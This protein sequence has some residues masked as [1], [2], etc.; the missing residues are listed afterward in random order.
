MKNV[1]KTIILTLFIGVVALSSFSSNEK[2]SNPS[3]KEYLKQQQTV[4]AYLLQGTNWTTGYV[5]YRCNDYGCNP[6]RWQFEVSDTSEYN[7]QTQGDFY[8]GTQFRRL[9]PNNQFARKYNFTH[10]VEVPGR[11]TAYMILNNL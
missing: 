10:Y 5:F 11:G 2:I 4:E 7:N 6:T 9:N 8:Q 3:I 1:K